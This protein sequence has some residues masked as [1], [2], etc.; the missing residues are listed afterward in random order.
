M[1]AAYFYSVRINTV[2]K[3]HG[4]G[5]FPYPELI[6]YLEK[7][8]LRPIRGRRGESPKHPFLI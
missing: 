3:A 4:I 7:S 2:Q 5:N 6:I 8:S 1:W